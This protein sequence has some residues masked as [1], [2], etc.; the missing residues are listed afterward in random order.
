MRV[1][2]YRVSGCDM[3]IEKEHCAETLS[4]LIESNIHTDTSRCSRFGADEKKKK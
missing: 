1:I 4:I 2:R 3:G